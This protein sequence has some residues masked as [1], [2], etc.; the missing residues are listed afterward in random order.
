MKFTDKEILEYDDVPAWVAA[1]YLGITKLALYQAL[2]QN[3]TPFGFAFLH[4][5]GQAGFSISPG[6]LVAYKRGTLKI[7][8]NVLETKTSHVVA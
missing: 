1:K 7:Q 8:V 4:E 3:K 6:L 5:S 2:K